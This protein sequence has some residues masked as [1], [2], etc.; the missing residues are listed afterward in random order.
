MGS[1]H[2]MPEKEKSLCYGVWFFFILLGLSLFLTQTLWMMLIWVSEALFF[3]RTSI[4]G[5]SF[6]EKK[7]GLAE[8]TTVAC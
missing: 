6:K 5:F 8:M 4:M 3:P 7:V 2:I 1:L